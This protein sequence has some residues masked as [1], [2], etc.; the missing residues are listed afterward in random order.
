[1]PCVGCCEG[2]CEKTDNAQLGSHGAV[3]GIFPSQLKTGFC[4]E[5]FGFLSLPHVLNSVKRN[6][7]YSH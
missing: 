4:R 5:V 3:C 1:M 6:T 7:E 2:K